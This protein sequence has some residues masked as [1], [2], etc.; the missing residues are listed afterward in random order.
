MQKLKVGI[1]GATGMVGQ[2]FVT[3]LEKHPWFELTVLAASDKWRGKTYEEVVRDRWKVEE[4]LPEFAKHYSVYSVNEIGKISEKADFLFSCLDMNTEE[5]K[6]IEEEY[7]KREIPVISNNSAHRQTKD[8]PM[9]I[10][11]INIEHFEVIKSQ[12]RR[13]GTK[14]G[15]IVTKPNC[16]LQSYVPVLSAWMEYEPRE[17]AVT[18]YQAVSGAGQRLEDWKDIWG[19]VIPYIAGEEKKSEEEPLRIWGKIRGGKIINATEPRIS[20]QCVRVPVQDGHLAAVFV[21]FDK[22]PTKEQLVEKLRNFRGFPQ[23]ARLPSA[24][25]QFIRY[26]EEEDRPQPRLDLTRE[27][28]MSISVGR[29]REDPIFDY[30]FIGLSHNTIRGAAGGAIL[31]AEALAEKGYL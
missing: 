2:R 9:V 16:S 3:L 23:E 22:K 27:E 30:K 1:L 26:L 29:L 13:L 31:C 15:F 4:P 14:R 8:V 17:V 25:K 24:P 12:K 18:T 10:P 6:R 11:E 28:K 20:S 5:I 19:N 7:A 21:K